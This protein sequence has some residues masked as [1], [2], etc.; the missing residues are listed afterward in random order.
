LRLTQQRPSVLCLRRMWGVHAR[1]YTS[2]ALLDHIAHQCHSRGIRIVTGDQ[3]DAF[4]NSGGLER[5][6]LRFEKRP[7][8]GPRKIGAVAAA[9]RL[10]IDGRR[11]LFLI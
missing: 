4:S 5:R 2:E 10:M 11:L 9:R 1:N 3:H 8:L 7:W 6:G